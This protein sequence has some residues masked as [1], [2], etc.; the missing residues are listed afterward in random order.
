M[1]E[2]DA[3]IRKARQQA[4]KASMKRSDIKNGRCRGTRPSMQIVLDTNEL[5]SGI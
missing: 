4:R 1:D 2:F 3:L 5:I